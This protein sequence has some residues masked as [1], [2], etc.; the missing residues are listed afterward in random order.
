MPLEIIENVPI[1]PECEKLD[2]TKLF[3][4]FEIENDGNIIDV[5]ARGEHEMLE[6]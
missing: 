2:K 3:V 5:K 4:I 1:F 6:R